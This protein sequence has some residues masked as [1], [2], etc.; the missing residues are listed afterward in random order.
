MAEGIAKRK[1]CPMARKDSLETGA[2]VF[3]QAEE[4]IM[5]NPSSITFNQVDRL[6]ARA[7]PMLPNSSLNTRVQHAGI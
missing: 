3:S 2:R 5:Y 6:K 4:Y 1:N 7:A